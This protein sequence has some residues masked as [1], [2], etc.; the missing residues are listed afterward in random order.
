MEV[1]VRKT[2]KS[3]TDLPIIKCTSTKH[4]C[5]DAIARIGLDGSL[6]GLVSSEQLRNSES[7]LRKKTTK[8]AKALP[9][10]KVW[11]RSTKV[12]PEVEN[13]K[14]EAAAHHGPRSGPKAKAT[15]PVTGPV[16]YQIA[17]FSDPSL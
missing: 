9:E 11:Q 2:D 14:F 8:L 17:S 16:L 12:L 7:C 15:A 5:R 3:W 13:I 1:G 10:P 6:I 4:T